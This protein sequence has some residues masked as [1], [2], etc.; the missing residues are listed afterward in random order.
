VKT[1]PAAINTAI[2]VAR[3]IKRCGFVR[4]VHASIAIS[5]SGTAISTN[6]ASGR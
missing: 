4:N 1:A 6:S 2:L 5:S 3:P